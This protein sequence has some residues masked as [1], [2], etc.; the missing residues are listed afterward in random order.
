[1]PI[2]K[3]FETAESIFGE[4]EKKI[5]SLNL[6]MS[7]DELLSTYGDNLDKIIIREEQDK[8]CSFLGGELKI[9]RLDEKRY[10]C[11]YALYF[12]NADESVYAVESKSKPLEM[13]FLTEDFQKR[14]NKEGTLKFEINEPSEEA[15]KKYEANKPRVQ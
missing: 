6:T 7:L 2:G 1:M 14:L 15:R 11:A 3:F 5:D 13:Q 10:E 9:S 4:V 8:K 12:E